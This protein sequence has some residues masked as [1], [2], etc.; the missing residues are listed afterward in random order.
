MIELNK[1]ILKKKEKIKNDKVVQ[2]I[3]E[4]KEMEDFLLTDNGELSE[5]QTAIKLSMDVLEKHIDK[6]LEVYHALNKPEEERYKLPDFTK[7]FELKQPQKLI[8]NNSEEG[9]IYP[10]EI[11][12][13]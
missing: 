4:I 6:G 1:G 12:G 13:E 3:K 2:I 5:L 7:L 9:K 11:S 8:T 10:N